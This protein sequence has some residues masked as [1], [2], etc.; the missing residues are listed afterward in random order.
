M[1]RPAESKAWKRRLRRRAGA[2]AAA[3]VC[4]WAVGSAR[5]FDSVHDDRLWAVTHVAV[6]DVASGE[7]GR[8]RTI[9]VRHGLIQAV[10]P[11]ASAALPAGTLTVDEHG[12]YAI[13]GLWDMHV[14]LR[15]GARLAAANG[16]WLPQYL[17]FGITAVR[18]CG[19]DLPDA[20]LRWKAEVASGKIH[21][22]RIFTSLRK[23]DGPDGAWAGSIPVTS[24]PEAAGAIDALEAKGAD[25]IKVYD[26]SIRPDVYLAVLAEAERRGLLTAGHIP[27]SV[28]FEDAIDAGLDS[29]E[30]AYH[31]LEAADPDD[32][33]AARRFARGGIPADFE[34]FFVAVSALGRAADEAHARKLFRKMAARG[35]ALTPTLY[36]RRAWD[37]IGPDDMGQDDP[38][39]A[40]VPPAIR[41]TYGPGLDILAY[42]TAAQRA[43]DARLEQ[44]EMR[45][46]HVAAEEGVRILAGTDTGAENPGVYP[47]DSLHRE[48][49]TLVAAGLT[50]LKALQGATI[51]AARW[52]HKADEFGTI[53]GGKAADFVILTANPLEDITNTRSIAAV[54]QQGVY[55]DSKKVE[56]L[57]KLPPAPDG[58]GEAD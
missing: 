7:V 55:F 11:A 26:G 20:V 21:G 28:P 24:A 15:G 49:E 29:V 10:V 27:L 41:E 43:S 36:I 14:H 25:F 3:A 31:L 35:A 32:R 48:L 34:P 17:G 12:R 22:P 6:I 2:L 19:G 45:L 30:H 50:P 23:I 9:V 58:G 53:A 52:F 42:R 39:L 5:A 13:P 4:L 44:L 1:D 51:E 33:A 40:A 18:D 47:G 57:R 16:R 38:R 37:R 54:V 56:T 46:T 8:D